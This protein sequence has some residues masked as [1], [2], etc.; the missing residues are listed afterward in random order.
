MKK[1]TK[2]QMERRMKSALVFVPRDKEYEGIY[3]SDKGLRVEVTSDYAVVSTGSHRHVFDAL[4]PN[5]M[6]YPYIFLKEFIRIANENDCEV[7]VDSGR[8]YSYAKLL[9]TLKDNEEKNED[10]VIAYVVDIW[11][12]NIFNPLFTIGDNAAYSFLMFLTYVENIARNAIILEEHTEDVTNK[13]II[14]KFIKMVKEMTATIEETVIFPK[15]TDEEFM[16][17]EMDA[18]QRIEEELDNGNGNL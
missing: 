8:G 17:K 1:L 6:S 11:L 15:L 7:N 13:Q 10:Y 14:A 16:Q 5:G 18:M 12:Y 3:F 4:T 2:E 9:R